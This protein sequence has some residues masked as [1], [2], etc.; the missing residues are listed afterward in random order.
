IPGNPTSSL[1]EANIITRQIVLTHASFT[2]QR[3]H[4]SFSGSDFP[5]N[6]LRMPIR[7]NFISRHD[8]S[9]LKSYEI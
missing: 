2:G 3:P 6:S 7:L 1:T 4:A 9:I 8:S 5:Q